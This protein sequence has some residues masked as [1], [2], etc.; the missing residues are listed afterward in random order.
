MSERCQSIHPMR[1]YQCRKRGGHGG[2]HYALADGNA[3]YWETGVID[4]HRNTTIA[5]NRLTSMLAQV[6]GEEGLPDAPEFIQRAHAYALD[7]AL[8]IR[9]WVAP[10]DGENTPEEADIVA[11]GMGARPATRRPL[12]VDP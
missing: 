2:D 1:G 11:A 10:D 5:F 12:R 3:M 7:I 4:R 8:G 9:E 6:Y